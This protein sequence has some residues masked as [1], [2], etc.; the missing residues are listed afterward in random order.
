[1][2]VS[3]MRE[4]ATLLLCFSALLLSARAVGAATVDDAKK[5]ATLVFYGSM[6]TEHHNKLI[7]AF[8]QKYPF[9]KVDGFRA[10]SLTVVNR[11]VTEHR[12]GRPMVDVINVDE[13]S[14]W[15]LKDRGLL[16]PYS[17]NET[18]AFP[19]AYRDPE[20][21]FTCCTY[22]VTNVVAYNRKQVR[23]DEA[24]K[25]FDDL[26]LP[27]WTEK[28]GMETDLAK[29]FAALV[30]LWG[31]QKTIDYFTAVMKQKPSMRS[32][33]SLLAQLMAA[34]EF[35]V[36]FGFYGYRMLELQETGMPLEIVQADPVVA[37]PFRLLLAKTLR[38][39]NAA[40]L[41]I[42]FVL[43]E[44]GQR[45]LAGLGRTVVRPGV[46]NKYPQLVEGVKLYPVKPD[47]GKNYEELSKT[48]YEI[49]N[50]RY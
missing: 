25:T 39:P 43:S 15:V 35:P 33:R 48:Y 2:I 18:R 42:D 31:R 13:L 36:G 11:V 8:N 47:I 27:K 24:P 23:K 34:G 10:N 3:R 21:F 20:N 49:I 32:G 30:P 28:L 22:I 17:S 38:H 26:L 37:W 12:T 4:V 5:E 9:V 44:E 14:G 41:F 45:F 7:A 6:T 19:E 40:K 16:Q 1:M 29:L 50:A 46:R